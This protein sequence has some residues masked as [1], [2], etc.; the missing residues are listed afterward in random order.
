MM[1]ASSWSSERP[2]RPS[3]TPKRR[4]AVTGGPAMSGNDWVAAS[5]TSLADDI[6][7][8]RRTSE[9]VVAA[10]LERIDAVNPRINAVVHRIDGVLDAA[11]RA[12][13]QLARGD[14]TGPLHGLP[15]T[16]KDSFDT[17]GTVT[18]AGTIGWRDRVP[19]T[20]ATVVAR[21]RAA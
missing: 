5:A 20:D 21:L 4:S 17:A 15:F 8:R 12:D 10:A 14:V 16:I 18:T 19:E 11:R 13:Q 2:P 6:R 9:E 7:S 1:R 3:S